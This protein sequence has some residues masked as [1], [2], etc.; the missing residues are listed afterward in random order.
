MVCFSSGDPAEIQGRILPSSPIIS[1][2]QFSTQRRKSKTKLPH[3]GGRED[4]HSFSVSPA[5][6]LCKALHTRHRRNS[7]DKTTVPASRGAYNL[8][9]TL[10]TYVQCREAV[11]SGWGIPSKNVLFS[12][13]AVLLTH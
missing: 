13:K 9:V 1:T 8:I 3:K 12:L 6:T 11:D 10:C 2:L 4:T 5:P 7:Q